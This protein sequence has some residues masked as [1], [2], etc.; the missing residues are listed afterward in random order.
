M[1]PSLSGLKRATTVVTSS[2]SFT[3]QLPVPGQSGVLQPTKVLPE[4][5]VAAYHRH[6]NPAELAL[7]A[8][9]DASQ[10]RDPLA[11]LGYAEV[12]VVS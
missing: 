9:G 6:V 1:T 2:S 4:S 3:V 10:I 5:A 7:V 12:T 8:V 11:N